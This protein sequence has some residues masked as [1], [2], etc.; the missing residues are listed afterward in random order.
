MRHLLR[1]HPDSRSAAVT[2]I[3]AEVE[4]LRPG[5]LQLTYLVTGMIG[6]LRLPPLEPPERADALWQHT[7]FEAFV[8]GSPGEAYYEF[9]FAPSTKWAAFRF[10]GYRAG[11]RVAGEI[12]APRI[13]VQ[14]GAERYALQ[15]SLELGDAALRLGLAAIIEESNGNKSYWAL[16]H[17]PGKPDFHHSVCFVLEFP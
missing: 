4:R 7:C 15:A 5:S 8:R 14:S 17:P 6:D 9:N 1:L 13:E 12:R 10:D 3:E 2:R 11:M 16:S